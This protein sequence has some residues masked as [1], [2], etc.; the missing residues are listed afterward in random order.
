[1]STVALL[2][3]ILVTKGFAFFISVGFNKNPLI[4]AWYTF[5]S[6]KIRTLT[7]KKFKNQTNDIFKL[8]DP[9]C[10][11]Q[12]GFLNPKVVAFHRR[13]FNLKLPKHFYFDRY[14]GR[15]FLMK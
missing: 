5:R 13:G 7:S 6:F 10:S 3:T 2:S 1:M 11:Y 8:F 15:T 12:Q 4:V 14:F 9:N